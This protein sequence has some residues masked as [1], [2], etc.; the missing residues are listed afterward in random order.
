[1]AKRGRKPNRPEPRPA[2]KH[3][4]EPPASFSES[5]RAEWWRLA[6]VLEAAGT[7]GRVDRRMIDLFALTWEVAEKAAASV[8]QHGVTLELPN[9]ALQANPALNVLNAANMRLRAMLNDMGLTPASSKLAAPEAKSED[10]WDEYFGV[11]G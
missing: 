6:G 3:G 11:V 2:T 7:I 4:W 9:G 1:M 8:A 10:Q 5:A